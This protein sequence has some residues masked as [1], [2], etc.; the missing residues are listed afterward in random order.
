LSNSGEVGTTSLFKDLKE[1][2]QQYGD[3]IEA[4]AL[5]VYHSVAVLAPQSPLFDPTTSP[6]S[7]FSGWAKLV[8]PRLTSWRAGSVP[9]PEEDME[10]T[11]PVAFS[12]DGARYVAPSRED[13]ALRV[14]DAESGAEQLQLVGHRFPVISVAF[15]PDGT[16]IVSGSRDRTVRVWDARTGAQLVAFRGHRKRVT[17]VAFSRDSTLV[18]SG[19]GNDD[20]TVHVWDVGQRSLV[21]RAGGHRK[22]ITTL[23]FSRDGARVLSGSEDG[24]TRSWSVPVPGKSAV[25]EFGELT[26]EP[27]QE[28]EEGM[29]MSAPRAEHKTGQPGF[30]FDD[31]TGWLWC[32][33]DGE[34]SA[35]LCWV[36]DDLRPGPTGLASYGTKVAFGSLRGLSTVLDFASHP[37]FSGGGGVAVA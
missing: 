35:R 14:Y 20:G 36:P 8:S 23:S 31:A 2:V 5:Q 15:S 1:T 17:S 7:T 9:L 34:A 16:R 12:L 33:E 24:T 25:G 28:D 19:G 13:Y 37:H 30:W 29:Q 26:Q 10:R 22:R 4:S 11:T 3:A 18:A 27:E 21:G 32:S 6:R